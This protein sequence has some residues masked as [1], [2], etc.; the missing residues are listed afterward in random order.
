MTGIFRDWKR[1]LNV[2]NVWRLTRDVRHAENAR[3]EK[4]NAEQTHT[5]CRLGRY[6]LISK[7]IMTGPEACADP[8]W[9]NQRIG[10]RN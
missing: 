9:Q 8:R 7:T 4:K 5:E 6:W 3:G 10:S 1:L 2:D